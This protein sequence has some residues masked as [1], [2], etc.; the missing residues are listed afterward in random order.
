MKIGII[1]REKTLLQKFKKAVKDYGFTPTTKN[2]DIILT[3]GGGDGTLLYAERLYLEI[4][5]L[6]IKYNSICHKC[7]AF[8]I[9]HIL[10]NLKKGNYK[11]LKIKKLEVFHKNKNLRALNDIIIRNKNQ[12]AALRFSLDIDGKYRGNFIG[13]G[14]IISTSFGST[15]YFQ[16]ITRKKFDKGFALAFNNI[17]SK[18][19][20]TPIFFKKLVKINILR[21]KAIISADNNPK[22]FTAKENDIITIYPKEK[23]RI[24]L[25]H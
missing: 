24:I 1:S 17:H 20:T 2:P 23:A 15:G 25:L 10:K 9:N 8:N 7:T 5:K 12:W 21:E 16:S 18:Q 19:K 13:D 11:E 4:P 6:P 3:I 14:V 22:T